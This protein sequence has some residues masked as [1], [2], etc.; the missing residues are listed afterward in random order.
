M[1][2]PRNPRIV[3]ARALREPR[4]RRAAGAF[5]AEGVHAV[6]AALDAGFAL[7]EVFVSDDAA[8]RERDLVRAL[9]HRQVVLHTVTDR[10][11]RAVAETTTPQ[12]VVAVV[13][14]PSPAGIPPAVQ[15]AV[16][17]DDCSDPG[18]AGTVIRTAD[19]AGAQLAAFGEGSV[20][21]WSGKCVRASAGSVFHLPLVVGR[22]TADVL[23]DLKA[24]GCQLLA[25][26]P[27]GQDEL[28]ELADTGALV[29]ATAWLFGSE[30]HGLPAELVALADRVVRI[31]IRGRAESLNLAAAAAVCLYASARAHRRRGTS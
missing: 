7:R 20:D 23:A 31:P 30:A 4:G 19:A 14:A 9:A 25:T 29:A 11:L 2:S 13:D 18:N 22:P 8:E 15:L 16:I 28:D 17:L 10:A 21:V 6:Q 26:A 12:G 1:D 24:A 3:A 5:L 27:D